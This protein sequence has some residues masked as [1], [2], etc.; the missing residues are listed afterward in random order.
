MP[1][2]S[3]Y[4]IEM[5]FG[6]KLQFLQELKVLPLIFRTIL[7]YVYASGLNLSNR[8]KYSKLLN[9]LKES[10]ICYKYCVE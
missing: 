2:E 1:L 10:E 8:L 3:K 9:F 4:T 7:N 6:I 5:T